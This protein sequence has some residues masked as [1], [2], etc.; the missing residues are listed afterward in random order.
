MAICMATMIAISMAMDIAVSTAITIFSGPATVNGH[1]M[2]YAVA[3]GKRGAQHQQGASAP[4]QSP[5]GAR[6]RQRRAAAWT[7]PPPDPG[8]RHQACGRGERETC[9]GACPCG[10]TA[11]QRRH[12]QR[13]LQQATWPRYPQPAGR[14]GAKR[15]THRLPASRRRPC[16]CRRTADSSHP[17]GLAPLPQHPQ[18]Q[19]QDCSVH[20]GP[21]RPQGRAQLRPGRQRAHAARSHSTGRRVARQAGGQKRPHACGPAAGHGRTGCGTHGGAVRCACQAE[22][23]CTG[24]ERCVHGFR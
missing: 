8:R 21:H 23:G 18:S 6:M 20:T 17:A 13:R 12:E 3:Q 19:H 9:H 4:H 11:C 2:P 16:G 15:A 1:L 22:Q 24:D 10:R 14:C 7:Q 5:L